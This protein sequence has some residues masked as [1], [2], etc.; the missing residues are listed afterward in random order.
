MRRCI[1]QKVR[2]VIAAFL[3]ALLSMP[4]ATHADSSSLFG[5]TPVFTDSSFYN[6]QIS[7]DSRY[8][9]FQTDLE[10]DSVKELYSVPLSGGPP[11]K[12]NGAL[13]QDGDVIRFALSPD[14]TRV[15]YTA[16]QEVDNRNELYSVPITGGTP[17]KLNGS[18]AA[19]GNVV[20]F[21]ISPDGSQV[22]YCADQQTND[23]NELYSVPPVGGTPKKLN[24]ALVFGG[25]VDDRGYAISPDSDYVVYNAD[26]EVDGR[27]ELYSVPI[28]GGTAAKL[29]APLASGGQVDYFFMDPA[30]NVVVYVANQG[31][32]YELFSVA[33]GGG[34]INT[35]SIPLPTGKRVT[36]VQISPDG[37]RVIYQIAA[38]FS[39]RGPLYSVLLGGGTSS[40]L[41]PPA[42]AGGGT[43]TFRI[44]ADSS[45]VVFL[46]MQNA[47]ANEQLYSVAMNGASRVLLYQWA[48]NHDANKIV[49]SPDADWVVFGDYDNS[50]GLSRSTIRAVPIG[51]G[52]D[53]QLSQNSEIALSPVISPDS[54]RVVYI[55]APSGLECSEADL[56]SVQIF[57]GGRRNLSLHCGT[58]G[59]T[60][61][62]L[63]SPDGNA[64]VYVVAYYIDGLSS[65]IELF[66]S[67]GQNAKRRV[68]LP[69]TLLQT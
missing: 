44:S 16:D 66:A 58:G 64:I 55:G 45:R 51:G 47:T 9:V 25:D 49:L 32:G 26:Q 3:F 61:E 62:A 37:S 39:E 22:V 54:S 13:V 42:D 35:L 10:R 46:F 6:A 12:L 31:S 52:A 38:T 14:G 36:Y 65:G 27:R 7:S 5:R 33:I 40:L 53:I 15:F 59:S 50:S 67:D 68:Y 63:F 30:I 1:R 17:V 21:F 48:A 34:V 2:Y 4:A 60:S 56:I 69:A 11:V 28:G 18:L 8:I 43:A 23:V 20:T 41:T 29:N 19:G 24:G 57:G